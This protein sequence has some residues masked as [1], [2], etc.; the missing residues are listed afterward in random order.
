M[1]M[2]IPDEMATSRKAVIEFV[3]FRFSIRDVHRCRMKE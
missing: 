2:S 1:G 3:L